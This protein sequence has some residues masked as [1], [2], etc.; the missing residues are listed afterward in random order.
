MKINQLAKVLGAQRTV[1]T[2]AATG[3]TNDYSKIF[4]LNDADEGKEQIGQC[5]S[6]LTINQDIYDSL[7]SVTLPA[8]L[9]LVMET[10]AAGGGKTQLKVTGVKRPSKATS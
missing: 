5:P 4:F 9:T 7:K 8:D 1:I 6:S 2:D 3:R 10:V